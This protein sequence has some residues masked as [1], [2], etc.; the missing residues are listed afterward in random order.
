[1]PLTDV[2]VGSFSDPAALP[3]YEYQATIDWGDDT[4]PGVATFSVG[5]GT[6]GGAR[7][8]EQNYGLIGSHIYV[9]AGIYSIDV[10]IS[11]VDGRVAYLSSLAVVAGE[12]TTSAAWS[13]DAGWNLVA[14]TQPPGAPVQ[15]SAV[16]SGLL[17]ST[18]G[19]LAALYSLKHDA[20]SPSLIDSTA[21][22][23]G[24]IGTDFPL[25]PGTGY[26]LY[27]DRSG[28]YTPGASQSA[29]RGGVHMASPGARIPGALPALPAPPT[30]SHD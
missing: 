10:T 2:P 6:H 1:V 24:M 9:A 26:L 27:S 19:N 4:L 25:L 14:L 5:R 29:S 17:A 11:A 16:L 3:A 20:W 21:S 18:G 22:G 30:A 23:A 8:I 15:A 12:G 28:S 13:I 7:A